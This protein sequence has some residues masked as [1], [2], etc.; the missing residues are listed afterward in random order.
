VHLD[1]A[2]CSCPS[3]ATFDTVVGHLQREVEIGGYAAETE[4]AARIEE[5][6]AAIGRLVGLAP[7]AVSFTA[8]ASKAFADLLSAWPLPEGARIG[9]LASDFATNRAF[10]DVLAARRG[11][12]PMSLPA[13]AAGRVNLDG[14]AA[15]LREGLDLVA[16][17]HVASHRGVVQPAAAL[18]ALCHERGV[19]VVLDAAQSAGQVDLA[20]IGADAWLAPSRKWLRGPRG[21]GFVAVAEPWRTR[22]DAPLEAKEGP[23]AARLGLGVALREMEAA[24]AGRVA[25]R[26]AA[27]GT[28]ARRRLDGLD[29]WRVGEPLDEPFGLARTC[30]HLIH[31]KMVHTGQRRRPRPGRF[32]GFSENAYS[33]RNLRNRGV[34]CDPSRHASPCWPPSFCSPEAPRAPTPL[35]RRTATTSG[36]AATTAPAAGER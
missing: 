11:V 13:D 26:I 15:A 3:Q 30:H 4:A 29:G 17:P 23:I 1:A 35:A 36:R 10:V 18:T 8:N 14:V 31:T 19:P 28:L 6:R 2:G 33:L 20:G 34:P 12:E 22:L 16:V 25:E 21:V 7:E 32:A 5:T 9:V 24:G 27:L